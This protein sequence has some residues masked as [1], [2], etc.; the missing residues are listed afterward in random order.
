MLSLWLELYKSFHQAA[1]RDV[2]TLEINEVCETVAMKIC[3]ALSKHWPMSAKQAVPLVK[4]V[5]SIIIMIP[6]GDVCGNELS[7]RRKSRY[8]LPGDFLNLNMEIQS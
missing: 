3:Q 7:S 6:Y 2:P 5:Q 4:A 1:V 8:L